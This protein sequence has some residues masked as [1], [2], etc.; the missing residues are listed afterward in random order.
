MKIKILIICII[1]ALT[2]CAK[3]KP[4]HTENICKIFEQ[5]PK[6][7][8]DAKRSESNWGVPIPIQMSI[9]NQESSFDGQAKPARKKILWIIPWKRPSTAYGY[10][11]ALKSTWK[12]YEQKTRTSGRRDAFADATDFVG[13]YANQ[14]KK[15]A[16]ISLT[17]PYQLYL[18]YHE[19]PT[20]Y[21]NQTYL[22]KP[23]LIQ[24]AQKVSARANTYQRQ[25]ASCEKNIPR[26]HWWQFW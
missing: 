17:N 10:T 19:G 20:G 1:L 24:S 11:Q 3:P 25:L 8:W 15:V 14:A 4:T 12:E 18:A 21:K 5:Y 9:I 22:T 23:W 2:G 26:P 7:Y 6:W 16:G 13:W